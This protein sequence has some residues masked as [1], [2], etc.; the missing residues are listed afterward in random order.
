MDLST[1]AA[2]AQTLLPSH[3]LYVVDAADLP[4]ELHPRMALQD[5]FAQSGVD[6]QAEL[7][8]DILGVQRDIR[9]NTAPTA[10]PVGAM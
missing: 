9:D 7:L 6:Q 10:Q 1:I 8:R 4:A 5:Y 2:A 3:R